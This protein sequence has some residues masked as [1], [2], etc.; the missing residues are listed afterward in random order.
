VAVHGLC[1][2]HMPLPP[3]AEGASLEVDHT[4][5]CSTTA[6]RQMWVAWRS[7][8]PGT[9]C[10]GVHANC[11]HNEEAA[12][13]LRSLAELPYGLDYDVGEW[14]GGV[15]NRLARIAR[16]YD[17]R[18]WSLVETALSYSG[19][20][21]RRYLAA[22]ESLRVDG[23]LR[24]SDWKLSAFLKAEK[25]GAAKCSKPR[26]IFPRSPRYNLVLAS[27]LKPF[28]HWLWGYLCGRRLWQGGGNTRVVAKGLNPRQRANLIRRKLGE[29]TDGVCFEVDGKA[30]EAHVTSAQIELEH[31]VYKAAYPRDASLARV[32]AMQKF[33]GRTSGGIRFSRPGGRASGDFNTGMGNTLIML[34]VCVGVLSTFSVRFDLLVDGDNALVFLERG[35]S[36]FVVERFAGRVLADC[37]QEFILE[38]EV[39]VLEQIR[40]GRSAPLWAGRRV[41]WT[42]VREPWS[43][44]SGAWASH[45]WLREPRF[46]RRWC[47][48]VAR[49]E[50]SLSRGVPVLQA[51]ACSV[52]DQT[53]DVKRVPVEALSDYFVVGA[54]LAGWEDVVP[55]ERE[56]R[57][58]FERAFGLSAEEQV[59]W[60]AH[61]ATVSLGHPQG[62]IPLPCACEWTNAEPG[63]FE[64][65]KDA[66]I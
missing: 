47:S 38:R 48:G 1:S 37:G 31:A 66:H 23:S 57:V 64:A 45:R 55:V 49:C 61:V 15:F 50:L 18:R 12:L 43:V 44:L 9:W 3:L 35:P 26:M 8:L 27:W 62:V 24:K 25:L 11:S 36:A 59:V 41:G 22:E 51:A 42:M 46:A 6:R 2:L 60:E 56:T 21:R 20:M 10:P 17:G 29:F 33:E 58:S 16:A 39:S 5:A 32:L 53:A 4:E 63:L 54:W 28:E 34:A 7:G 40:F 19:S 65:Y 30:F 52:L 14:S 13:R